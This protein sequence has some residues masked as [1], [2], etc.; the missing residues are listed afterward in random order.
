VRRLRGRDP[1]WGL[2]V[3]DG[4][5][6]D[7][8]I[9]YFHGDGPAEGSTAVYVLD[10]IGRNCGQPGV[11]EPPAPGWLD[12]TAAGGR[13]TLAPLDG[14]APPPPPPDADAGGPGPAPMLPL[15]DERGTV[16]ALAA[17]HPDWLANSCVAAGGDNAFLFELVRR[18]RARDPRW[19][20]NWKRGNVGD[21]SQDVVDYFFAEGEPEGRTEVYIIDVIGDHCGEARP[22][23]T[24]V[25]EA[26]R[27]G[28]T[29][30]RW[31]LQPLPQ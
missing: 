26:T 22:A 25:T 31:T 3:R 4:V 30:G 10:V 8:R 12:D 24:D 29:I 21:M 16:E 6:L 20:L 28:G 2:V 15:P 14:E 1:R 5:L 11:D 17:E 13:F 7:D 23:F 19:G 27:Q 9:A 18:L